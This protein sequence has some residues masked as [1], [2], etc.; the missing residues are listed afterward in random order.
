MEET[1]GP[2]DAF[3]FVVF[4]ILVW[5]CLGIFLWALGVEEVAVYFSL[6][7]VSFLGVVELGSALGLSLPNRRLVDLTIAVGFG[8]WI[9]SLAVYLLE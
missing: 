7:Y 2:L 4:L 8:G 6:L 1:D 5:T 3:P 9:L